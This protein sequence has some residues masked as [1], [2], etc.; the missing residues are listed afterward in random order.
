[1][2]Y[3]VPLGIA[4]LAYVFYPTYDLYVKVDVF[5]D[6]YQVRDTHL[7][8]RGRCRDAAASIAGETPYHCYKTSVWANMFGGYT[9]YNPRIRENQKELG[10]D[11][12]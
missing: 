8:S 1:M 9:K 7:L 6:E 5:S 3:L 11:E 2:K 12:P 10:G 4:L